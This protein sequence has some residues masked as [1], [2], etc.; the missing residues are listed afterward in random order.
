MAGEFYSRWQ[1]ERVQSAL[2]TRRIV[3]LEGS[4]QCGKTTLSKTFETGDAIYRTLDDQE[5][6]QAARDDPVGFVRHGDGLL[7]VDEV[8]RAP[9]LLL[10]IKKDVDE[11]T[12]YGRYLLTGS[13]HIQS[14]PSVS[15]SLAGRVGKARLR[16]LA[17]GEMLGRAAGFIAGAF[18]GEFEPPATA[19]G[20]AYGKDR[21]ISL[22]MKGGFP[23]AV[24]LGG[25][26]DIRKWHREYLDALV[27]R[28]L[29]DIAEI[30]R[31]NDLLR[32]VEVL[33]AWSSKEADIAKIGA[34]LSLA[35]NTINSYINALEALCLVERVP[36]WHSSDYARIKKR[37]KVFMTDSG[38]MSSVLEWEFDAVRLDGDRNGKLMETF[39]HNQLSAVL[40][41][42]EEEY[43]LRHYRDREGREIDLL[44]QRE[45]GDLLGIEVKAG[46]VVDRSMFRHMDWFRSNLAAGRGFNGVV[47][48]TG[49]H[50]VPYGEGM[51]AVPICSL[52]G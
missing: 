40:E 4:R 14:L 28:D 48:Y 6:R 7:I 11:N 31:K 27:D 50:V 46:P 52:W 13:A 5:M 21:Y 34:G 33:A 9:D 30:R 41:A 44:V 37:D 43:R 35:R 29:R 3:L 15:E 25:A 42:Q 39:V 18:E 45:G 38:F 22:A 32:L 10:A 17:E 12:K 26:R 51:W 23:E 36:P 20:Q 49:E 1:R 19:D 2:E 16:P 8:Q 24:G 47:L